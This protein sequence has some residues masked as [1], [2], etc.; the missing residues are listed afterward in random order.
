MKI[1]DNFDTAS[2]Q[3]IFNALQL[4]ILASSFID[5]IMYLIEDTSDFSLSSSS[6]FF[7]EKAIS[8][9]GI[10]EII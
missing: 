7:D 6:F 5:T 4:H 8:I 2:W 3:D 9:L 1:E 10:M